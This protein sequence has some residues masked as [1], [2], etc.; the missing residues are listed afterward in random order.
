M[1]DFRTI[2]RILKTLQK[3]MDLEEIDATLISAESL[4]ISE[5]RWCRLM[6][7][8]LEEGYISGG[9]AWASATQGYPRVSLTR[10]EITLRGLEYLQENSMMRKAA[11]LAKGIVDAVR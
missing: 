6:A 3:A 9:E 2:Y 11:D 4:G 8:L 5:P 7:L 10:P 1:E